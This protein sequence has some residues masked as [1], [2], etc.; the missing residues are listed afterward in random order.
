MSG[1]ARCAI[2]FFTISLTLAPLLVKS[3]SL[4]QIVNFADQ[5]FKAENYKSAINEYNRAL[6]FGYS[7]QD[8]LYLN[9]ANSYFFLKDFEQSIVF[10][11]K[12]YF[13]TQ[14]DSLK[15]EA[16]LGKSFSLIL[17][18]EY[19]LAISETMNLDTTRSP[20]QNAKMNLFQ[21]IAYFGLHEDQLA[22][23]SF[24][25]CLTRLSP[26]GNLD[27]IDNQFKQIRRNERRYNPKTA[28]F[29]S[30][31]LPGSGQLYAGDFKNSA[32]SLILV[33]G[34]FYLA[35]VYASNVSL[36]EALFFALPWVQRYYLGGAGKAESL[37]LDRQLKN[38]NAMYISVVD[39]LEKETQRNSKQLK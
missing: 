9:V 22:T 35:V 33:G 15:N 24:K 39:F 30:L 11:D 31:I 1:S 16:I 17:E 8:V 19:L 10:Y 3:Q 2:L 29:L 4:V 13:S 37:T 18:K 6:F 21:G 38:R 27:F 12:T 7:K 14:S 25:S 32:N 5:Q 26:D 34:L 28:W 20:L 23:Q 36:L